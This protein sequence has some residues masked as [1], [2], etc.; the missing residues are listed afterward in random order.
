MPIFAL[1]IFLSAFLLFQ[2]QAIA[3]KFLMPWFG[4]AANVWTTSLLFFQ[5]LLLAGY[6]YAHF[7]ASRLKPKRNFMVHAGL[8][9]LA[10]VVLPIVPND[11]L[12]P[13]GGEDPTVSLMLVLLA[14]VGL[15]Y[16][17]LSAASPL[18][19]TWYSRSY[20]GRSPY[21]LFALSNTGSLLGLLSYPFLVEPA[22]TR[23][24]QAVV[25]SVGFG[26][27]ALCVS[28]CG[29]RAAYRQPVEFHSVA[30][31]A[32]LAEHDAEAAARDSDKPGWFGIKGQWPTWFLW[33][34]LGTWL[35]MA[36]S[37]EMTQDIASVPFLWV[38]P[39]SLYLLSFILTFAGSR[40]YPRRTMA[41]LS[42]L[43]MIVYTWHVLSDS[44]WFP[45][46][47]RFNPSIVGMIVVLS[48]CLL[49]FTMV[50]HGETYLRRP[51]AEKLTAFY[52]TVS[53]GG[54]AGG[55]VVSV[56]APM[57]LD[58]ILENRIAVMLFGCAWLFSLTQGK[59][60]LF[61]RL[62][63]V[64]RDLLQFASIF[65][66]FGLIGVLL[67][68]MTHDDERDGEIV[69]RSR[70]FYGPLLISDHPRTPF[71]P[72]IRELTHG[73]I[74]HGEQITEVG[75]TQTPT[76]Y[77]CPNSGLG[78]ALDEW[79][80][81]DGMRVGLVGLG[82]GSA[83]AH[84]KLGQYWRLYELDP[85]M[86]RVAREHFTFLRDI[87]AKYDIVLGDARLSLE[88]EEPNSFDLLAVDAFTGDAIPVHLLTVEAIKLYLSHLK[89][90]GVV[91]IHISNRYLNLRPVLGSAA[92]ELGLWMAEKESEEHE[93]TRAYG[94]QWILL[95][96]EGTFFELPT[97][98]VVLD[99]IWSPSDAKRAFGYF[100]VW[101]D[102]Y[103]NLFSVLTPQ[104]PEE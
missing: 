102:E 9:L 12:K 52:L 22:M 28:W 6:A 77:Y 4:G 85:N 90:G 40:W 38:L 25:W 89:P 56:L 61:L 46:D 75:R 65:A 76:T 41:V 23:Q 57:L 45:V 81:Q 19:Q 53:A 93:A 21:A 58:R 49:I 104:E 17:A 24:D 83:T 37:N 97:V 5:T 7:S 32:P 69:E 35:L 34:M 11:A 1:S 31:A 88:R 67:S 18:I 84:S 54:A 95:A 72:S 30:T 14:T 10:C 51:K 80:N 79:P 62:P 29:W 98:A 8:L 68:T 47:W 15:P 13:L 36:F 100:R 60:H 3:A 16:L 101:T 33:P 74:T 27:A 48:G 44:T 55:L 26:V 2:V 64:G 91:A 94:S 92:A 39:L 71:Y 66:I 103:S 99:V 87:N 50:A 96:R 20:P 43:A 78:I 86:V 73:R 82:T 70:T 59:R 63:N 42:L